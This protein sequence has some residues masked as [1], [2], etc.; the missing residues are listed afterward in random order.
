MYSASLTPVGT[1]K[2]KPAVTPPPTL[3]DGAPESS[4]QPPA[5]TVV[6]P[7]APPQL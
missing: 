7:D 6:V 3:S 4:E 2:R 5:K 1:L